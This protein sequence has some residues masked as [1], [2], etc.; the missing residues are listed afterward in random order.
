MNKRMIQ[1]LSSAKQGKIML[2]LVLIHHGKKENIKK[3]VMHHKLILTSLEVTKDNS[4][5][6]NYRA[7]YDSIYLRW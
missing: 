6:I 1:S 7:L 5:F 2:C 4:D 3:T